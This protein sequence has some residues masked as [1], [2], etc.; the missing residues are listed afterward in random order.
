MTYK[1]DNGPLKFIGTGSAF[2]EVLG[3]N[4]AYIRRN[5][6]L[7]LFD[8]GGTVFH[9]MQQ[10]R[11][12]ENI[13]NIYVII[14]HMHPDHIG[15]L[16]DLI[17]NSYY[18]LGCKAVIIYPDI[19]SLT[20]LLEYMGVTKGFYEIQNAANNLTI[21]NS[22]ITFHLQAIPQQHTETLKSY[23]YIFSFDNFTLFYSGDSSGINEMVLKE[24]HFG[25][26]QYFYQDTCGKDFPQNPHMHIGKL[27][28]YMEPDFRQKVYCM[29][30]DK[31]FDS[32]K[33]HNLG[34]NVAQPQRI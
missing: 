5:R 10:L 30:L 24:F 16:G 27:A 15:S 11:L 13:E 19:D 18:I 1:A 26:I 32:E 21:K 20:S 7:I 3:N 2:N 25:R 23:G 6:T 14:T 17:F 29:H 33:A 12:F 34:F 8:C 22:D 28:Q 9:R 4:S 31:S